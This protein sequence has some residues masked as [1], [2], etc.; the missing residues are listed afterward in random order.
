[1]ANLTPTHIQVIAPRTGTPAGEVACTPVSEIPALVAA[2]RAAQ[3]LWAREPLERRMDLLLA[4]K[5]AL[6]ARAPEVA[7]LLCLEIGKPAAEA[8]SSEIVTAG[9][10][11]DGW[12]ANIEDLL[13]PQPVELSAINYPGKE[14]VVRPVP[15]GVIAMIMPWN[16]PFHLPLR[17]MVPALLAGN[18]V[19]WKPSEHAA[20]VGELLGKI[21]AGVFPAG[22]VQTVQGGG[23]QGEALARAG[24]ERIVFTGSVATGRRVAAIAAEVGAGCALE[25]GSKDAAIVLADAPMPRTVHGLVW[26]A[27]HNAGQDCAAV[28][29]VYVERPLYE[30]FVAEVVAETKKLRAGVDIGPLITGAQRDR[31]EARI[32]AAVAAGAVLK[33]GGERWG[34]DLA[35]GSGL[36]PAVLTGVP[37]DSALMREETFGPVMPILPFDRME[38]VIEAV[39]GSP[40]GLCASVWSRD[41]KKARALMDQLDVGTVFWNNC[42]FTGPMAM[43]AW[44][45]RRESG[46]GVTGSRYGLEGLVQPRTEVLDS[47]GGAKEMWWHPYTDAFT[48]M[49]QGLVE[50]GRKGGA[51]IGGAQQVVR[52]LLGRWRIA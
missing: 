20:R 41:Q 17:T 28:E 12:L 30:R 34:G 19:V 38:E 18:A 51:K 24:C 4:F 44:S 7:E 35:G 22:L 37:L 6:L 39:N 45:G 48:G 46:G 10:L 15:L 1:M 42:C 2:A 11:F 49:A 3:R 23:A 32:G 36:T 31:V 13:V 14:V 27:F 8:W 50:L 33:C 26:G 52:G 9:E 16:Y 47:S 5:N 43:A 40:Y 25:L 29:R 21:A